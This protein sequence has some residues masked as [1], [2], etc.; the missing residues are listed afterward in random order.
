MKLHVVGEASGRVSVRLAFRADAPF[1]VPPQPG[2]SS[3]RDGAMAYVCVPATGN[4][5]VR[6]VTL[7]VA[8]ALVPAPRPVGSSHRTSR[9]AALR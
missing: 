8:A 5:P 6:D 9:P 1:D 3:R 4:G 7:Q 2:V